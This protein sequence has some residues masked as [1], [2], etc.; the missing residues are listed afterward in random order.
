MIDTI[1]IV[2]KKLR[3]YLGLI[4]T[5]SPCNRS[6]RTTRTGR[7]NKIITH[8]QTHTH[9]CTHACSC[10][11]TH[12]HTPWGGGCVLKELLNLSSGEDLLVELRK[13][14]QTHTTSLTPLSHPPFLEVPSATLPT[15][16]LYMYNYIYIPPGTGMCP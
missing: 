3:H 15:I 12:A 10:V 2:N 5:A 7:I 14:K 6:K 9:K 16:K 1:N 4:L 8:T 11:C 13:K